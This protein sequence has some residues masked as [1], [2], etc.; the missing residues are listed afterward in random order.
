M[1]ALQ[2]V[3]AALVEGLDGP[4]ELVNDLAFLQLD[5]RDDEFRAHAVTRARCTEAG[6]AS[7]LRAAVEAAELREDV[8]VDRLAG[9]VHT[10]YNG[11]LVL[12]PLTGEGSLPDALR[13]AVDAVLSPH[14]STEE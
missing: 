3:L 2:A 13:A 9:A 14:R 6:I 8:D 11:A 1:A 4:A 10:A 5:P 12:W 7:L